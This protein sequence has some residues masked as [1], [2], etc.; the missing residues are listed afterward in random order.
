[1][2]G[3]ERAVTKSLNVRFHENERVA[4]DATKFRGAGH[5]HGS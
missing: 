1:M 3:Y 2:E 4:F 5:F